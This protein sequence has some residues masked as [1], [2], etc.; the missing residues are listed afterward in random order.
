MVAMTQ[1]L[2]P[3][4]CQAELV[5]GRYLDVAVLGG[6]EEAFYPT[7]HCSKYFRHDT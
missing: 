1:H 5:E 6:E 2:V 7:V 3:L 4:L